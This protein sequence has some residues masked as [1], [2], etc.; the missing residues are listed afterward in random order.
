MLAALE[1]LTFSDVLDVGCGTGALLEA[2]LAQ[3]DGVRARGIDLS[4][5]MVEAAGRRLESRADL[6]VADAEELPFADGSVDLV[7]CADSFHHYPH[8]DRAIAEMYRVTRQG[9]A[10]VLGD[11]YV[12]SVWRWL[13]NWILP[14]TPSGDVRISTPDELEAFAGGAGYL[15]ERCETAGVRA[16]VLVARRAD[17]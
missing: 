7:L 8:P 9:G 17:A 1:G 12:G 4:P 5:R 2:V 11:W 3:R 16:Q 15:V 6:R 13:L 10:L 14:R